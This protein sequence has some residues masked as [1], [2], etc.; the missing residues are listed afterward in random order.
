MPRLLVVL[1]WL[2]SLTLFAP[3]ATAD[4][5][6][7]C[8]ELRCSAVLPGAE[9]FE[10]K[11]DAAF[12][13]GYNAKG[14]VVGWVARSTDLVDI[15][16]Y[17][18]KPLVTLIS[19]G[20]D[21]IIAGA[22]LIEHGEPILLVG[23][24]EQE[25]HDFIAKYVGLPATSKVVVGNSA[26]P[27]AIE[28][29]M[30]SGATVTALVQNQTILETARTLG[31]ATGAVSLAQAN[32]G[33][34]INSETL[35]TWD[36]MMKKGVFGRL[37][38][39]EAEIGMKDPQGVLVDLW[40]TILDAPQVGRA[41]L[42]DRDY[43]YQMKQL[44]PGQHVF[45]VLGNGSG[46]FKGSA[47]VRG[48][49][50]DRV[51][52][53]QGLTEVSFRDTDYTNFSSLHAEGAPR[54]KEGA[55]FISRGG[56]IDP[57]ADYNLLFLGSRYTGAYEREFHEFQSTHRLPRSIYK[58]DKSHSDEPVYVQ[59]WRNRTF[60]A[61]LLLG[62][63]VLVLA[64][65]VLRRYSTKRV[66]VLMGIHITLMAVGFVLI[67]LYM[68][69]QPSVTQV[70]TLVGT[71]VG[72]ASWEL[73]VTAPLIFILWIFIALVSVIWGRGVFCGWVC[74]YGSMTE[75][76]YKIARKLHIPEFDLPKKLTYL[77]YLILFVLIGVFL[78]DSVTAELMAEVEPF[79]ST[80]L[81][82]PW[83]RSWGYFAYWILLFAASAVMF[84]PFCRFLCPLGAALALLGSFRFSGPRRRRFCSSCKICTNL[85]E[86][87]AFRE[88]G[89][90]DPR[91]CLSCMECEAT[92]RDDDTCPPLV[93]LKKLES[94]ETKTAKDQKKVKKM[95]SARKDV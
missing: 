4:S 45:M 92:Y 77:R 50:F 86:P 2:I 67:G 55:V 35:L 24:P 79:K 49:I 20:P 53:S 90:I 70:L 15:K 61:G 82:Y 17:S 5:T 91:E 72:Q 84:R 75:L 57:G 23:I 22:R 3:I 11:G 93:V 62:Y 8:I 38:V 37:T 58:V 12:A 7:D 71:I 36:Q 26:D 52:F 74:P 81:L 59:A 10:V 64:V 65:F 48:G 25:L 78:W 95:Q 73:F 69:A 60:D 80:F 34:F 54:F 51:R 85:C 88:D 9:R 94:K 44:E 31:L 16:A 76:L 27:N 63:L 87:H 33:H 21:G 39:T 42:G 66:K 56:E 32:P 13:T 41:L 47:F 30:I 6:L 28:V 1:A 46:S 43:E 68:H 89:T 19:L 18:G 29:D 14:E 83:E 40:Y